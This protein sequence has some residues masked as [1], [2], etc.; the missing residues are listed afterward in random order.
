M[1]NAMSAADECVT[2]PRAKSS[3]DVGGAQVVA[4]AS[5][6]T[7]GEFAAAF[8]FLKSA[9]L[10]SSFQLNQSSSGALVER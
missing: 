7:V 9:A 4:V 10:E 5:V 3:L 6:N 1:A 8:T 2:N